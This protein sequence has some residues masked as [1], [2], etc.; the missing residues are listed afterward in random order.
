[1]AFPDSFVTEL[2]D[3]ND[4]VD[5]VSSYVDLSKKSGSNLF[6]L[7]PFHSEKTPS[8]SVSSDKQMYYCFGCQKGGGVINFVMEME[9][10]SYPDAIHFLANRAGMT[11]PEE[12]RN[13]ESIKRRERILR[14]NKSAAHFF[15]E[16]LS[17]P[18]GESALDYINRRGL[19][20]ASVTRFGIGA[21]PDSWDSLGESMR[22]LG[23]SSDDLLDAGLQKRGKR[24][25]YDTFRN[26][27][28]FPL[29]DIRGH[30]IGFSGRIL[31]EGQ[32][33]Y[34]NSPDTMVFNKSRNLFALNLAKKS[35]AG[36][37]L[38]VEGN[39][40]VVSLHQA[41]FDSA[42]AALGT[43]FTEEQARLISRNTN[44]D[45]VIVA[46]DS[47]S[48][49]VNASNRAISI[50]EKNGLEVKV[51]VLNGAKDPDE[52]IRKRGAD[53][54]SNLI[55]GS[56]SHIRFKLSTI[57][58]KYDLENPE[59]KLMFLNEATEF[60]VT[61]SNR[62]ERELYARD[63]SDTAGISFEALD[64]EIKA[65]V[66]KR[67]RN[68][69]K[70]REQ[71]AMRP[72]RINQPADRALRYESGKT[73]LAEEG[74][75]RL[76]LKDPQLFAKDELPLS[77]DDFSNS[78]LKK[79]F[80]ILSQRVRENRSVSIK[81]LSPDFELSEISLLAKIDENPM[82]ISQSK[83]LLD[84]YINKIKLEKLKTNPDD[85]LRDIFE[86]YRHEKGVEAKYE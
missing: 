22:K 2:I 82:D 21:A 54:F 23:F 34:L 74:I 57:R 18:C 69:K 80:S 59:Q 3:R 84:D 25:Q 32:P 12:G 42:V 1:M 67:S 70:K 58:A 20:K 50:L 79:A 28:I 76:L 68:D 56:K 72:E 24:G 71:K 43:S 7:C 38:L 16:N 81:D 35:K 86:K 31:D 60:L 65:V 36:Y 27:L 14:L 40:D 73:V 4:I 9:A 51:L 52:F 11:V 64:A 63:V 85:N 61:L 41:G 75:I 49:G 66:R 30:V 13:E 44:K 77:G 19:S 78:V 5:V 47:D 37:I 26:R 48:A 8:F 55:D 33:K 29:I 62:V 17:K 83:R 46:F 10:L 15:F 6:G 45:Q 53:A 39:I